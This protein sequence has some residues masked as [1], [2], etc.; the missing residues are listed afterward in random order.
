[1]TIRVLTREEQ[2]Y[3]DEQWPRVNSDAPIPSDGLINYINNVGCVFAF[4]KTNGDRLFILVDDVWPDCERQ[5][6]PAPAGFWDTLV[7]K[8]VEVSPSWNDL[9]TLA[10]VTVAVLLYIALVQASVI[11]RQGPQ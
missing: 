3:V 11:R 5:E 8:I 7:K 9:K 2:V 10:W 4:E 1:M 6:L